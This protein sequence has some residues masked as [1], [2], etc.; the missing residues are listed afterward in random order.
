MKVVFLDIDGVLVT[1]HY[2]LQLE[3]NRD[4]WRDK[5]GHAYFC[6]RCLANFEQ[7]IKITEAKVVLSSTWRFFLADTVGVHEFF[8]SRHVNFEIYDVTP[9]L[10]FSSKKMSEQPTRGEEIQA[11]LNTHTDVTQYCILDDDFHILPEQKPNWVRTSFR[12]GFTKA[13]LEKALKILSAAGQA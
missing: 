5:K 3:K 11:W 1:E 2:L 13:K 4:S 6:P 12:Y 10:L 7:L 8:K 9:T